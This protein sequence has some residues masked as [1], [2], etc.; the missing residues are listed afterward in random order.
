MN[1]LKTFFYMTK[2]YFL[3]F[4]LHVLSV[5]KQWSFWNQR[6]IA[7][8]TQTVD[9]VKDYGEKRLNA[10]LRAKRTND[11]IDAC[12]Y[13]KSEHKKSVEFA[14]NELEKKWSTRIL[15]EYTPRGNIILYYDAYRMGFVYFSDTKNISYDILNAV[16]MKYV[17]L[18]QCMDFFMDETVLKEND[19]DLSPLIKFHYHDKDKA[20]DTENENNGDASKN[21]IKKWT[22][23][24]TK[25]APFA[26]L[27]T[28]TKTGVNKKPLVVVHKNKLF[29]M[30][31]I[32]NFS[33]CQKGSS[34]KKKVDIFQQPFDIS[35]FLHENYIA[36]LPDF[37]KEPHTKPFFFGKGPDG[38]D[39]RKGPDGPD[40][41]NTCISN[42]ASSLFYSPVTKTI[43]KPNS[44][45]KM[46]YKDYK[47]LQT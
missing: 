38:P 23:L 47:Y 9:S 29:Y 46:S 30:G 6:V 18:F 24:N 39:S 31:K 10:F 15:F 22:N 44:D 25:D 40:E 45:N 33:P 14:D 26:T 28:Y 21:G 34:H 41:S 42:H 8:E 27:K 12:F 32:V 4:Y 3:T 13:T 5:C 43:Q 11:N 20:K 17:V 16:I 37:E 1:D 2:K 36:S 35:S 7:S 19:I